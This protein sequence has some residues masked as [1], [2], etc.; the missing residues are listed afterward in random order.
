MRRDATVARGMAH[1]EAMATYIAAHYH[2]PI[3][4][5]Q[6]AGHV[7]LHPNYAMALFKRV[8]GLPVAAYITRHRLSHAQAMLLGSDKKVLAVAMDC[9]FGSLSSFYDAFRQHL[10]RTPR[11]YRDELRR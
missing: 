8:V 11:E 9:G 6:V 4:V 3:G 10:H 1:V 7:G 2:E 5:T